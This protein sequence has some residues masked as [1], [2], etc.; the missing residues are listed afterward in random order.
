MEPKAVAQGEVD[1]Q[2]FLVRTGPGMG[3]VVDLGRSFAHPEHGLDSIL[4][5]GY[6]SE[7]RDSGAARQAERLAK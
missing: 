2:H 4:A 6:W 3:R 1:D 7:V 5:R